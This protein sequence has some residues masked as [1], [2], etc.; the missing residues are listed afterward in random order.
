MQSDSDK[1]GVVAPTSRNKRRWPRT[2]MWTLLILL[3]G[4]P[5]MLASLVGGVVL[6]G[7]RAVFVWQGGQEWTALVPNPMRVALLSPPIFVGPQP[8]S[9]SPT[10]GPWDACVSGS[11]TSFPGDIFDLRDYT[12]TP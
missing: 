5:C 8:R 7:H 1:A 6:F 4:L 2:L 3:V 11:S 9:I 10:L 12:C